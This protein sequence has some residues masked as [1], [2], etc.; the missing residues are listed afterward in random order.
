MVAAFGEYRPDHLHPG[1]DFSTGG[2][3][4][5]VVRAP[6]D[7][8]I[9]RLKV[10]W[11]GY[12]RALY[13]RHPDGRISVYAH[14]E[15]FDD[16]SLGLERRVE[17]ARRAR[18]VRYPGDIFLEPPVPVRRGA[19]LALSGESGAGLPH[20]HFEIRKTDQE[21]IDP[22]PILD[23]PV[24]A[25][26][27]V[28]GSVAL[29]SAQADGWVDGERSRRYPLRVSADGIYAPEGTIRV[30]GRFRAT[31]QIHSED[32]E[33]HRL[34]ILGLSVAVDSVPVY[35]FRLGGFRFS[36][37]PAVGVLLDH[38]ASRLSPPRYEYFLE[39]LPGNTLGPSGEEAAWPR[40]AEGPHLLEIV[41]EAALG[42]SSRAR[43]PFRVVPRRELTGE[44]GSADPGRWTIRLGGKPGALP[45]DLGYRSFPDGEPLDCAGRERRA[46]DELCRFDLP[47]GATGIVAEARRDGEL[48]GRSL[49]P[50]SIVPE[51]PAAPS[52]LR[53][54]PGPGWV[55]LEMAL[56]RPGVV[57][58]RVVGRDESGGEWTAAF[59]PMEGRGI[60][61]GFPLEMWARLRELALEWRCAAGRCL[62]PLPVAF[63][64]ARPAEALAVT[65]GPARLEIPAGGVFS[66]TAVACHS[67]APRVPP[68]PGLVRL[69]DAVSLLPEGLPFARRARFSLPVPPGE[70]HPERLAVYREDPVSGAWRFLGGAIDSGRIELSIAR[71]ETLALIR[72]D[73]PP[74]IVGVDPVSGEKG[75]ARRPTVRVRVVDD[76]S[77][78]NYDG[79]QVEVDGSPVESEYDPDRGWALARPGRDL[80]SGI[81]SGRAW[82]IDRAGNRSPVEAFTLKVP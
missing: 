9:Y 3:T 58:V 19:R 16:E 51:T 24:R 75:A 52:G 78:L 44:P 81:R 43:I 14:L 64:V 55:D 25:L 59:L 18:G 71:T 8:E 49:F 5:L 36:D 73:S 54:R 67:A 82:A 34:G 40:L 31:A 61:A 26:P 42:G 65:A 17:E 21:P 56:D 74:R 11:R 39:R 48:Q 41:A 57:P 37:Y 70:P 35:R 27:P 6:E 63:H 69:G 38:A 77:G 76:G 4:G 12:G 20:L 79:V 23:F 13:L 32:A 33:G 28:M 1:V 72:D 68:P 29:T 80:P 15:R 46:E 50:A 10:E 47:A 30:S 66:E 2:R 7:G 60:R 62:V 53:V 45:A 22:L